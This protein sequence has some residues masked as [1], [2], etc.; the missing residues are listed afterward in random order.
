MPEEKS[1][2]TALAT[3]IATAAVTVAVGVT[4][5]A[6][7]GY[8]VPARDAEPRAAM[9][10][11]AV[12]EPSAPLPAVTSDANVVLVPIEPEVA[13]AA[14]EPEVAFIDYREDDEHRDRG[15]DRD[16][17]E[18]EEEEEEDDHDSD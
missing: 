17:Q 3:I 12:S 2:K 4:A 16:E 15:G 1:N 13:P 6:L 11:E 14:P 8:L 7:G 18:R 9:S 5:A 10:A